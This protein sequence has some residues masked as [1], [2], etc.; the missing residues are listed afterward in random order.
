[1]FSLLAN[2][3]RSNFRH[4]AGEGGCAGGDN[5]EEDGE[6]DLRENAP[7]DYRLSLPGAGRVE[8]FIVVASVVSNLT[9]HI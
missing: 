4:D 8:C 7:G 6:E 5:E 2:T 1:M 9:R 3:K